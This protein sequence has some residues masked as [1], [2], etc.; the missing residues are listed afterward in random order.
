MISAQVLHNY[1]V[2]F[3]ME[4]KMIEFMRFLRNSEEGG[5]K[6][7][8]ILI[9]FMIGVISLGFTT[10]C[11]S[12]SEKEEVTLHSKHAAMPDYVL[13]SSAIVQDTYKLAAENP[14]VL[15]AVPCYC[16]CYESAGHTS[17]RDCFI[18]ELGPNDEVTAWD[19]HGIA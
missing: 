19:P 18:K 6:L 4:C 16:N 9:L 17:N 5:K 3:D 13:K 1:Q 11:S 14:D 12:N 2:N 7:K 8:R 15:G 10:G